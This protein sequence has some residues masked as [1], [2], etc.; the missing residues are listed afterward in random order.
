MKKIIVLLV[1]ISIN[2]ST[3]FSQEI[4]MGIRDSLFSE[5]LQ[6]NRPISIYFPPS[7]EANK[8]QK[9]PVLYIL[10]GDYNFR[11]V[12]GLIELQSSISENI[13]EMIV[14]GISGKGTTTYRKNCKPAIEGIEDSG[15]ADEVIQFIK[16]ELIPFIEKKYKASNYNMLAGHSVGG[17]FVINT[18]LKNPKL[19]ANYIAISP[20]LWWENNS[21]N[22]IAFEKINSDFK[23]NAYLSLANE[24]GMGVDSFLI[25]VTK[26][27]LKNNIVIFGISIAALIIAIFWFSKAQKK[28]RPVLLVTMA[29]ALSSYLYFLYIPGDN[30]FKFRKFPKENHNSVGVP[31][32]TW[33]LKDI[34]KDW[35]VEKQYFK[36]TD[37]L[38]QQYDKTIATYGNAFNMPKGTLANT[39][40]YILKDNTAELNKM[41]VK[42]K[43]LY[44]NSL[45]YFNTLLATNLIGKK[46]FDAAEKLL[47]ETLAYRPTSYEA[48]QKLAELK[49]EQQALAQGD[50]LITNAIEL[51]KKEHVRQWQLNELLETKELMYRK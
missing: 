43:E 6:E 23:T 24:K 47:L 11:Y 48:Y 13:P 8:H 46:E 20:A 27:I 16:D 5:V 28:W 45:A 21:I 35:R 22:T 39:V 49:K 32:Y 38:V 40:L 50:S 42:I 3:I 51:A 4:K 15:N 2:N 34:F 10:D 9:F 36:S 18:V 14:V 30:N 17:L 31:T 19:F 44:P 26:S 41:Q 12:T 1:F 37:E 25:I 7:Y 33:A 29:I